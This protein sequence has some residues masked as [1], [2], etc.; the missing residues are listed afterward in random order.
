VVPLNVPQI[1]L[2][3]VLSCQSFPRQQVA[4]ASSGIGVG[5]CG[6]MEGKAAADGLAEEPNHHCVTTGDQNAGP[7]DDATTAQHLEEVISGSRQPRPMIS[8]PAHNHSV[9]DG[10]IPFL[11]HYPH[12]YSLNALICVLCACAC[13]CVWV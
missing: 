10:T 5:V 6:G 7:R 8:L 9:H 2:V 11:P 1:N 12:L 13:Q 4:V 3:G